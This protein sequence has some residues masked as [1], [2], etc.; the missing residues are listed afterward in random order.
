MTSL[1]MDTWDLPEQARARRV[2]VYLEMKAPKSKP[3]TV[4]GCS[5]RSGRLR[6]PE[7]LPTAELQVSKTPPREIG[8]GAAATLSS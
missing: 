1:T 7:A 2:S 6:H 4:S 8:G 5:G 3:Q